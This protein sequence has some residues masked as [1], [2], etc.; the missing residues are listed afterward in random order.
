MVL[1][2]LLERTEVRVA[3]RSLDGNVPALGVAIGASVESG[4]APG[5]LPEVMNELAVLAL[6]AFVDRGF[7]A[8]VRPNR[9]PIFVHPLPVLD[10]AVEEID[11]VTRL[12]RQ[13]DEERLRR[14]VMECAER[15]VTAA[16]R[17]FARRGIT[18]EVRLTEGALVGEP[19]CVNALLPAARWQPA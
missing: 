13:I 18:V 14:H 3:S 15:F 2:Q 11:E 6:A 10:P 1:E 19:G 7:L 9:R 12:C 8:V 16:E 5:A 4:L 17:R